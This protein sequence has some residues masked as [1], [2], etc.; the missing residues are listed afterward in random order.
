MKTYII[1]ALALATMTANA[2]AANACD[3]RL[4][5]PVQNCPAVTTGPEDCLPDYYGKS[6]DKQT[7][8]STIHIM[9]SGYVYFCATHEGCI[10]MKDLSFKGCKF[11]FVERKPRESPEYASHIMVE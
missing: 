7:V 3:I 4:K 2:Y 6:G 5:H 11:T 10:E 9:A 1:A 8:P